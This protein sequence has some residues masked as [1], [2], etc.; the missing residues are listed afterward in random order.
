MRLIQSGPRR[1]PVVIVGEAP[2]TTE[3]SRGEPFVGASGELLDRML[4]RSGI[5]RLECFITNVCHVQPP[6]NDFK[7]FTKDEGRQ[8]LLAG[9]I[10]L[11]RDLIE[12]KP[13]LVIALGAMPLKV[14]TG[15]EGIDKYRG[16]ILP[17]LDLFGNL[18]VISTY[19]PAFI[20]RA[21]DYKAVAELDLARCANDA[22]FKEFKLPNRKIYLNPGSVDSEVAVYSSESHKPTFDREPISRAQL[23]D[24]ML[25]ARWLGQDIECFEREDGTWQLACC[26]FSDRP[27]R[28]VVIHNYTP[29]DFEA[30]R[31]LS[32]S[33]TDKVF[34][35]GQF[36]FTVLKAEGISVHGYGLDDS[37]NGV[38]GW[39]TMYA[40]H[41]LYPEC[42]GGA[43]EEDS[44]R[45]G[46]R[47]TGALKKGL[48]FLA[49]INTRQPFYK[50]DG[51]L[52]KATSDLRMFWCYN[53]LDAAVTRECRD[54][55]ESDLHGFETYS[56]FLHEMSLV[57]PL[58]DCT[59]LGIKID[60]PERIR[61]KHELEQ[62]ISRLQLF[63]DAGAGRHINVSSSGSS[64]DVQTLLYQQLGLPPEKNKDT[65]RP[66]ADKDAIIKLAEKHAHPLLLTI[67]AIR[68]RRKIVETY[69]D[70]KIDP[71]GRIRCLYDPSGTNTGRLASRASLSGS[72]QNL[73]NQPDRVRRLFLADPGKVLVYRDYGQAEA[74][75][76]AYLARCEAMI[77]IF[78]DRLK[79]FHKINASRIYGISIENVPGEAR[80]TAKR[81]VHSANYGVGAD[82]TMKVINQDAKDT[83]G[84]KGTGITVDYRTSQRIV[85]GYFMLYP[86]IKSI[87]WEDVKRELYLT[88]TLTN[89]F[90]RKRTFFGRWEGKDDSK[91]L[92]A[93]YSY[94]PQSTVGDLAERALIA[95]DR[96]PQLQGVADLLTNTHDANMVQCDDDPEVVE[97][98]AA[99]MAKDMAIP[100]TIHGRTFTIPS[101]CKVGYNWQNKD[102]DGSN[103]EGLQDI[104]KWI[105]ARKEGKLVRSA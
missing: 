76:V 81:G 36:D 82:K 56:T 62:E 87:W 20:L 38:R 101:D 14:L 48:A 30:I 45:K 100:M 37:S 46:T 10:Q 73:Q 17:S 57:R 21:W 80:F 47:K 28:A 78:E 41:S 32:E 6:G 68:E 53:G 15:Y 86:E 102:K 88:R 69:M 97:F 93:A 35:N 18:K 25:S 12:I 65:G 72:G 23:I 60:I 24:E 39:D 58:M 52:W 59:A 79:D 7:W 64:G 94:Q 16:S 67:L 40:H 4:S 29:G 85:D 13:N 89:A 74:R 70:S 22:R 84:K 42:A 99:E 66:T 8:H 96:N 44:L 63:L 55:Q 11:Q 98:V 50:D 71:D 5:M 51:K 31:V 2:G 34:Q 1:S 104:D 26:G 33:N 91:F 75:V 95:I 105:K 103:P 19:H 61:M 27:D 83:W 9:M 43:N 92:N 49:S 77:E 3:M 54:V 90:G